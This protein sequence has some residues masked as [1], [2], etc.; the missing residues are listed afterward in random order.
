M[1]T[2]GPDVEPTCG[3]DVDPMSKVALGQCGFPTSDPQSKR[4]PTTLS[5]RG[6][7]ISMLSGFVI[8]LQ[9]DLLLFLD[10]FN[11]ISA[12]GETTLFF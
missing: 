6:P 2:C 10:G 9:Y 12:T 5:P 7:N 8:E 3:L 4:R 11:G 1:I